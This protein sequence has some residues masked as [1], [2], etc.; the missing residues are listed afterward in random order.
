MVFTVRR[1]V[2]LGE[3]LRSGDFSIWD[4]DLGVETWVADLIPAGLRRSLVTSLF[5]R[6]L[7]NVSNSRQCEFMRLAK[8]LK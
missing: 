5:P 1:G 6:M 2:S 8:I 7:E 4:G 3:V